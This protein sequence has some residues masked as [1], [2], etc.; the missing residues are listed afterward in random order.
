VHVAVFQDVLKEGVKGCNA[1]GKDYIYKLHLVLDYVC[2]VHYS[3]SL[4]LSG[5]PEI[6]RRASFWSLVYLMVAPILKEGVKG[7]NALG[8]DYIYKL[9]LVLDY[10]VR[11]P[12][13]MCQ[14]LVS[15]LSNG[16]PYLLLYSSVL[17]LRRAPNHGVRLSNITV[18]SPG[19]ACIPWN[20]SM[21]LLHSL[22]VYE[23][24]LSF[25]STTLI[26]QRI[27]PWT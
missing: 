22:R 13:H 4:P 16:C 15:G 26:A 18:S 2:Q 19:A 9:H 8:K 6:R 12:Q 5:H 10:V 21:V 1:L 27:H 17:L 25:V 23:P 14:L 24:L 11:P 7:C 20:T 3:P